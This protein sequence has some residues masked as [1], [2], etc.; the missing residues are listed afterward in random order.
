MSKLFGEWKSQS[1]LTKAQKQAGKQDFAQEK[2]TAIANKD[3]ELE[4]LHRNA[5]GFKNLQDL[6]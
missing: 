4:G 2:L 5:E 1:R 3:G 6:D